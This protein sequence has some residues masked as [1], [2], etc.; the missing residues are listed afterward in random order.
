M[1]KKCL[2]NNSAT[3]CAHALPCRQSSLWVSRQEM[4]WKMKQW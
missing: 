3:T 2:S 1:I 4:Y